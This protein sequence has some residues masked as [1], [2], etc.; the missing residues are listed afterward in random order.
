MKTKTDHPGVH[1][2]PPLYYA[3][4][5]VISIYVQKIFPINSM[6]FETKL[7]T[8]FGI[9]FISI[10]LIFVFPA[11]L[12]FFKTKNTLITIKPAKSLQTTGIYSFS[13]NPM[14]IGLLNIYSGLAF[15]L[16]CWWTIMFIPLVFLII[17]FLVIRKEELY[18]G[19]AFGK[20]YMEYRKKVRRWI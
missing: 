20:H 9:L 1:V 11:V 18:L 6:F 2:P 10:G 16:G 3:I 12:R 4:V 13:R 19:R 17:T 14:Y 5:F 7:A 15:L 8:I